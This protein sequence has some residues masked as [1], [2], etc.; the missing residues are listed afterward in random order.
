MFFCVVYAHIARGLY[1]GSYMAP[2][3]FLWCSGVIILLLMMGV[4]FTGYVLPWGQMSFWGAT[5]ITSMASAIPV[6]GESIVSWL[7]GG[8]VVANPT[9][10]RFFSLHFLLPFLIAG[11][12]LIHLGLLHKEGSNNPVGSDTGIDEITFYPYFV[13]KDIFAL[14]FFLIFFSV[15]VFYFPNTLN[16]PDNYI[17]ADPLETPAHVVPEWYERE[18]YSARQSRDD[19]LFFKNKTLTNATS[20]VAKVLRF[21]T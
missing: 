2:R 16:H 19:F 18:V 1:Y 10:N 8:F 13:S 21:I 12:S 17:S 11:L 5:V 14:S 15:F 7:W 20:L 6:V 4:A 3:E 9:L